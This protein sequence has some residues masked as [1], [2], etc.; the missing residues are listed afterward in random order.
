MRI[1][2]WGLTIIAYTAAYDLQVLEKGQETDDLEDLSWINCDTC[3][4]GSKIHEEET[5]IKPPIPLRIS[6][7][8][9]FENDRN[10]SRLST[11]ASAMSPT[12]ATRRESAR[13]PGEF[14]KSGN[15]LVHAARSA[16]DRNLTVAKRFFSGAR[17]PRLRDE[18]TLFE[19]FMLVL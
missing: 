6:N 17:S 2:S 13:C 19:S 3:E 15:V 12:Q 16:G 1:G 5:K 7:R 11:T 9:T 4:K 8:T 18:T 10:Q 14:A